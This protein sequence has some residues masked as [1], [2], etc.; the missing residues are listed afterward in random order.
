MTPSLRVEPEPLRDGVAAVLTAAGAPA[1]IAAVVADTLVDSDLKGVESH[2]ILR[3]PHYVQLIREGY[4]EPAGRPVVRQDQAAV[5]VL[6]GQRGF[7]H[8]A[9]GELCDRVAAKATRTGIAFG[10]LVNATHT[11]RIGWFAERVAARAQA[12]QIQGGG[13]HHNPHHATVAPFGGRARLLGTNPFT[14]GWPGGRF[15]AIVADFSTSAAAEGK[16]RFYRERA[17]ALPPGWIVTADGAPATDPHALYAGG[18]ILPM[19]AHKGYGLNLFNEFLGGILL[20]RAYELN[21]ILTVLDMN[22]FGDAAAMQ[23]AA[24]AWLAR[25]KASPPA[26]GHDAVWLPG[27]KEFLTAR[28]RRRAGIPVAPAIWRQFLQA[29]AA[30]DAELSPALPRL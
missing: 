24:E 9:L 1:D 10:G 16:V 11:G 17:R 18:A 5:L 27:E 8:F 4:I 26:Q 15:G 23:Q 13:A 25:I 7:G 6:D 14:V 30:V 22:A 28:Q 20:G 29:A 12:V 2:G 19:G 21:W 3:V